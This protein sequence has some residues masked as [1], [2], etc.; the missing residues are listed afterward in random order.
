MN[1][2]NKSIE[3]L[4]FD[5]E[6]NVFVRR[7]EVSVEDA[8]GVDEI[9]QALKIELINIVQKVKTLKARAFKIKDMLNAID[10]SNDNS[11]VDDNADDT[12]EDPIDD[13]VEDPIDNSSSKG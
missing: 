10:K 8:E 6:K 3:N 2:I 13:T 4:E 5:K 9:K 7:E 1:S 11:T 12:V